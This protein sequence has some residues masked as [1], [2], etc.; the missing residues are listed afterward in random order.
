MTEF[1]CHNVAEWAGDSSI[2]TG[3]DEDQLT[4]C[5]EVKI[6]TKPS[7]E[8]TMTLGDLVSHYQTNNGEHSVL[9]R[10][11]LVVALAMRFQQ[12][13]LAPRNRAAQG[14]FWGQAGPCQRT[15]N[16]ALARTTEPID[17]WVSDNS[18]YTLYQPMGRYTVKEIT[19]T[20]ELLAIANGPGRRGRNRVE[21]FFNLL[22]VG[23]I[24][25]PR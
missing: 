21:R 12:N 7:P 11:G 6:S 24:E 25:E 15:D 10:G 9:K 17:V 20:Q 8:F 23:D 22:R 16:E 2:Q 5:D 3:P 19:A 4:P 18:N 14:V 1:W 13:R